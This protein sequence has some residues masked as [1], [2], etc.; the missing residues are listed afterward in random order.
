MSTAS[1]SMSIY[2]GQFQPGAKARNDYRSA[3]VSEGGYFVRCLNDVIPLP[4][5]RFWLL[6]SDE[7]WTKTNQQGGVTECYR[8]PIRGQK[9]GLKEHAIAL[10]AVDIAEGE[11][12]TDSDLMPAKA[13][14]RTSNYDA[15]RA[16]NVEQS[17]LSMDRSG[18]ASRSPAHRYASELPLQWAVKV[19]AWGVRQNNY[20]GTGHYWVTRAEAT[21]TTEAEWDWLQRASTAKV[22][23]DAMPIAQA[24]FRSRVDYV[25]RFAKG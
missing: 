23:T 14:F 18:W 7:F 20:Y 15:Y 9:A 1:A 4:E 25:G 2:L 11:D 8:D 3:G 22:Y 19:R 5:L 12:R 17:A 16:V 6:Y 24:S 13:D 10:V 21:P